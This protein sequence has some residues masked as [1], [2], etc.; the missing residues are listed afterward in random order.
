MGGL[1]S[2]PQ[3]EVEYVRGHLELNNFT[4]IFYPKKCQGIPSLKPT[5][6]ASKMNAWKM[7]FVLGQQAY[8][9]R[10]AMLAFEGVQFQGASTLGREYLFQ[11][12]IATFQGTNISHLGKAGK[13]STQKCF[14]RGHV[15]SQEGSCIP[16]LGWCH[17]SWPLL[18]RQTSSTN[19][20]TPHRFFYQHPLASC[21][22]SFCSGL[23]LCPAAGDIFQA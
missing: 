22:F 9:Q 1:R 3:E 19:P 5:A 6:L 11:D 21:F 15:S 14:K 2:L 16:S 8:F 12:A 7:K 18:S 13:T 10:L 23:W 20:Q 4:H 17:I